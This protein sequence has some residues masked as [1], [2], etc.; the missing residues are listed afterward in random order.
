MAKSF[1][2]QIGCSPSTRRMDEMSGLEKYHASMRNCPE[3]LRAELEAE[4]AKNAE[5]LAALHDAVEMFPGVEYCSRSDS[6]KMAKCERVLA[7][8]E[9]EGE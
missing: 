7:K 1:K 9:K 5:L 4:R 3:I 6:K 8:Y 2:Q